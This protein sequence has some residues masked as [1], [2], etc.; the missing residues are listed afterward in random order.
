[1]RVA[2]IQMDM[3]FGKVDENFSRA[4]SL[5]RKA[6]SKEKIDTIVLPELWDTG[7]FP[8]DLESCADEDGQRT[9]SVFTSIAQELQVNIVAGS[10]VTKKDGK[11]YN[12]AYVF[13]CAGK[14][15]TE[16]DKIHLFSPMGED[17]YFQPGHKICRFTLDNRA[18]GLIICYDLRFPEL[19]RTLAL[20]G[21]DLLFVVSQWPDKRTMHLETL[22]RARAIENQMYVALCNS[23]GR[24]GSTQYAGC[25]AILDPWGTDLA[26]AG[27]FEEIIAA[28]LDSSVIQEI[29]S[30]INVFRDRKPQCYHIIE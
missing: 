17:S 22:S 11:F 8:E 28:D 4:E 29:R 5:I 20:Q 12:T 1:M 25:S 23:C 6:V 13:D 3:Q 19:I 26:R 15:V 16:Y 24:A 2:C 9:K 14:V 10:V 18:C 7:F 27:T 30:T 21:I